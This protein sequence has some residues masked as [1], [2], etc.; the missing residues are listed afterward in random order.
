[1]SYEQK[2]ETIKKRVRNRIVLHT[3]RLSRIKS[4]LGCSR[5]GETDFKVLDFH[6]LSEHDKHFNIG[7]TKG[8]S[9]RWQ[10][11]LREIEKCEILCANCHRRVTA[12]EQGR[13]CYTSRVC[14]SGMPF[15][16]QN[17]EDN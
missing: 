6:H 3:L 4:D 15:L 17:K 1:M 13:R 10:V 2:K 5:C 12:R 11:I 16:H 14:H 8:K 7:R 9:K